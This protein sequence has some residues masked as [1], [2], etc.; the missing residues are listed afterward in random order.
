M[1]SNLHIEILFYCII[2]TVSVFFSFFYNRIGTEV[3]IC[4][5]K[6]ELS[7]KL[8]ELSILLHKNV[9]IEESCLISVCF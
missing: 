8:K 5:K 7:R 3:N 4:I 9:K 6:E 2:P 1:S